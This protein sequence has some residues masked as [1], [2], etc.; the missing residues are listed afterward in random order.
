MFQQP[1]LPAMVVEVVVVFTAA[2]AAAEAGVEPAVVG[3]AGVVV[4]ITSRTTT[5]S[6]VIRVITRCMELAPATASTTIG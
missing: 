3:A 4:P 2:L 6:V 1:V 5:G